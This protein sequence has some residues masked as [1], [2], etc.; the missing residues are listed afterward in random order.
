VA[1][2]WWGTYVAQPSGV[3]DADW[4]ARLGAQIV[5]LGGHVVWAQGSTSAVLDNT[6]Y[7]G[8]G[9]ATLS[10][11]TGTAVIVNHGHS[12]VN[13]PF[14]NVRYD[15]MC[16]GYYDFFTV[17]G[18]GTWN[19]SVPVDDTPDCTTQTLELGKLFW[20]PPDTD[21][22]ADCLAPNNEN[23]ACWDLITTGIITAARNI[24]VTGLSASDLGGTQFVAGSDTGSDPTAVALT[25]FTATTDR[26]TAPAVLLLGSA[27]IASAVV[28]FI[29]R[30]RR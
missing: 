21:Y 9:I 23:P 15:N 28:V 18:S 17:N 16:S 11:G 4:Q 7:G 25:G 20:I 19:V 5:E 27:V 29:T 22:A 30:R 10:G 6:V 24:T 13:A 2:N 3:S 26:S 12:Y 14:G 1:H 8:A